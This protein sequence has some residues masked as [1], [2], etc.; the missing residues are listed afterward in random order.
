M[1]MSLGQF[2]QMT[3]HNYFNYKLTKTAQDDFDEVD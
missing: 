2:R 1:S 3:K